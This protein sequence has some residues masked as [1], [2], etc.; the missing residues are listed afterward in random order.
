[1]GTK[2]G[3]LHFYYQEPELGT[4]KK[5]R[6]RF[7]GI[8]FV[9]LC[10]MGWRA[11]AITLFVVPA[12]PGIDSLQSIHGLLKRLRIRALGEIFSK[13][14]LYSSTSTSPP[15][16]PISRISAS[17]FPVPGLLMYTVYQASALKGL[18]HEMNIFR[19][20][21]SDL[22]FLKESRWFYIFVMPCCE[23]S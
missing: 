13:L 2:L 17:H 4:V 11:G 6:N 20:F 16:A 7:Q 8:D 18:Y 14:F 10:C 5:P 23:E 22:Y 9:S 15:P 1:M 3:L 19:D 21:K 12:R